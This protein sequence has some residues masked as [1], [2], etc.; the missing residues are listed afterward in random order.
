MRRC[1]RDVRGSYESPKA[2]LFWHPCE[3]DDFVGFEIP[4]HDFL[5][6]AARKHVW[7]PW[8]H[9]Q[10]RHLDGHLWTSGLQRWWSHLFNVPH[11][12]EL[13]RSGCRLPD[14]DGTI[15]RA[16]CK[17]LISGIERNRT[18]PPTRHLTPGTLQGVHT[19]GDWKSHGNSST[20]RATQVW[21][22]WTPNDAQLQHL[23]SHTLS[24]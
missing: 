12:C 19:P 1:L 14:L 21:A 24:S 10:A 13:E 16:S 5:V 15:R 17:P 20:E 3:G 23:C 22:T 9:R 2:V 8:T 4:A 11:Q 18:H 6:E 7:M